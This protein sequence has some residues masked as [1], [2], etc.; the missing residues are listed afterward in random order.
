MLNLFNYHYN[1]LILNGYKDRFR[2]IPDLAYHYAL[3]EATRLPD[4]EPAILKDPRI[5]FKYANKVIKGRW[6]ELEKILLKKADAHLL[7]EYA[8]D[9]I[10][11]RWPEA[12]PII[13]KDYSAAYSYAYNILHDRWPEAEPYI[14]KDAFFAYYYARAVVKGR[15]KEAEP[16]IK[17]DPEWWHTYKNTFNIKE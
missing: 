6:P 7:C 15:W 16:Y 17:E 8:D 10:H 2:L 14:M 1:P 13:K 11:D 3:R 4:Y 9:I 5:A 12:E